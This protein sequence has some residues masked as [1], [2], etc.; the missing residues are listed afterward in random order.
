MELGIDVD[1]VA[2][3]LRMHHKEIEI[4][5]LEYYNNDTGVNMEEFALGEIIIAWK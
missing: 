1:V 2:K 5:F 3:A 4:I